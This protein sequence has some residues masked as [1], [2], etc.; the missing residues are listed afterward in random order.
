MGYRSDVYGKMTKDLEEE[1]RKEF[2]T[3]FEQ[4]YVK[5]ASDDEYF[6]LRWEWVKWYESFKE[7]KAINAWFSDDAREDKAGLIAIGEDNATQAWGSPCEVELYEVISV[8]GTI[9]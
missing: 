7:V 1:F 6:Y 4:D 5:Y 9:L 2:A 3:E 8:E